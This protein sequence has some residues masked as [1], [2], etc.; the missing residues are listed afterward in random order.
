VGAFQAGK[1][2]A[3][4]LKVLEDSACPACGSCSGLFTANSMKLPGRPLGLALLINGTALARSPEREAL[5][6]KAANLILEL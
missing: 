1:I 5:A 4:R 2:D 3:A 6:V